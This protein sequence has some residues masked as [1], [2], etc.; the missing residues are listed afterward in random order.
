MDLGVSRKSYYFLTLSVSSLLDYWTHRDLLSCPERCCISARFIAYIASCGGMVLPVKLYG[1]TKRR[2]CGLEASSECVIG[3][4]SLYPARYET[5]MKSLMS[6]PLLY[7][8]L[9]SYYASSECRG[10]LAFVKI[11]LIPSSADHTYITI[12]V[13]PW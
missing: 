1:V 4:W 8:H 7:Y 10:R 3:P 9:S 13:S 11:D 5:Y 12:Y 6:R 2:C